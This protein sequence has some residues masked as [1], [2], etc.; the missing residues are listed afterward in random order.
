MDTR[1]KA[2]LSVLV[3]AGP[4]MAFGETVSETNTVADQIL[5]EAKDSLK[6]TLKHTRTVIENARQG[7]PDAQ[8][9]LGSMIHQ[10][11]SGSS[12]FVHK[13]GREKHAEAVLEAMRWFIRSA[14]QGQG[15]AALA[16][17]SLYRDEYPLAYSF[18]TDY[19]LAYAWLKVALDKGNRAYIRG[20][21]ADQVLRRKI[22]AEQLAEAEK[23][24]SELQEH[25]ESSMSK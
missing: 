22:T 7:N 18:M 4:L 11:V 16:L 25:I 17:Y 3:L 14:V 1:W 21:P 8:F 13:Y 9:R 15:S 10:R 12:D 20:Q 24:A 6:Q 5:Q 23:L 2:W 19:V